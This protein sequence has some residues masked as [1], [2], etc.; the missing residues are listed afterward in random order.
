MIAAAYEALTLPDSVEPPLER[1]FGQA[2]GDY[3][4]RKQDPLYL[5]RLL[6]EL[7]TMPLSEITQEVVDAVEQSSIRA[8]LQQR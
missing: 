7:G 4:K 3:L 5:L 8:D 2:L 6:D 1:L